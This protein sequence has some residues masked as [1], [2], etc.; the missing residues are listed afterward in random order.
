MLGKKLVNVGEVPRFRNRVVVRPVWEFSPYLWFRTAHLEQFAHVR[1]S[2]DSVSDPLAVQCC[3]EGSR[4][5]LVV[6]P[7]QKQDRDSSETGE[8]LF[9][10]PDLVAE[11]SKIL[12]RRECPEHVSDLPN[13][14][15]NAAY[16]GIILRIEVNVFSNITPAMSPYFWFLAANP[17]DTAPPRLCP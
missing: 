7:A 16:E 6:K 15:G 1:R 13:L 5:D 10:W 3:R 17:I 8:S 12:G 14:R 4:D 11:G 2:V 9:A